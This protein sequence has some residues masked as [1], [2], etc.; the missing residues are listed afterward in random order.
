MSGRRITELAAPVQDTDAANRMY[1]DG[2]CLHKTVLLTSGGWVGE[3]PYA[4][5]VNV[6]GILSTDV[7]HYGVVYSDDA[8]MQNAQKEAFALVDD[9]DSG[10]G[11]VT[12]TCFE[13][14]PDVDLTI[15]L[16]VNR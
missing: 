13:E 12:F 8:V 9:L 3:G 15:Q 5:T 7:A 14:K 16:E 1:V 10:E 4:Q 6:N 11:K 2:K